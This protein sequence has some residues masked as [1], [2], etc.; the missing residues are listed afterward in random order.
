MRRVGSAVQNRKVGRAR[1]V[2]QPSAELGESFAPKL[3]AL[4]TIQISRLLPK[5]KAYFGRRNVAGALAF[6][7]SAPTPRVVWC[8][9]APYRR[10]VKVLLLAK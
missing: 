2:L 3:E 7:R 9:V 1:L 5:I 10:A 6:T 8:A 4:S